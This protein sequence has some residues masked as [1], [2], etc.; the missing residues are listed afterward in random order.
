MK[1]RL[2]NMPKEIGICRRCDAYIWWGY[3]YGRPFPYDV[4]Y[5]QDGTPYRRKPHKE[6]C[7]YA[8]DYQLPSRQNLRERADA[9]TAA[10]RRWRASCESDKEQLPIDWTRVTIYD[11]PE[12]HGMRIAWKLAERGGPFARWHPLDIVSHFQGIAVSEK[13]V[14]AV[15]VRDAFFNWIHHHLHGFMMSVFGEMTER[16]PVWVAGYRLEPSCALQACNL[17]ALQNCDPAVLQHLK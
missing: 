10:V 16:K 8:S 14:V 7:L 1:Y 6:S 11:V 12:K 4:G 17:A 15:L 9:H 5:E 2:K 3:R 13:R